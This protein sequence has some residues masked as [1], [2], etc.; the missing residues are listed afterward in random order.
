MMTRDDDFNTGAYCSKCGD[1]AVVCGSCRDAE[2][3]AAVAEMRSL[4]TNV[5]KSDY[6]TGWHEACDAIVRHGRVK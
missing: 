1:G 2:W 6:A 3:R 5:P 4:Y